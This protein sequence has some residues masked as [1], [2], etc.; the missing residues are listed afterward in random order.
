MHVHISG[1]FVR[2]QDWFRIDFAFWF[3]IPIDLV[4]AKYFSR[5][6]TFLLGHAH[7]ANFEKLGLLVFSFF[8]FVILLPFTRLCSRWESFYLDV[9]GS[10]LIN[11]TVAFDVGRGV[12]TQ[13]LITI[14]KELKF[15]L[16]LNLFCSKEQPVV[17]RQKKFR[18]SWLNVDYTSCKPHKN[19]SNWVLK[20]FLHFSE[21]VTINITSDVW[22]REDDGIRYNCPSLKSRWNE[23]KQ[24]REYTAGA[25]AMEPI[26]QQFSRLLRTPR[27]SLPNIV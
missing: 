26:M 19:W 2:L 8:S 24:S 13:I 6:S 1:L 27:A 20:S 4:W 15:N 7:N 25:E 18:G 9:K 3:R 17:T 14:R 23:Y 10:G 22:F 21:G 12:S 5:I 11:A 16:T